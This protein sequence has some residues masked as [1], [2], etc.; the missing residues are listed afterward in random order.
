MPTRT[1]TKRQVIKTITAAAEKQQNRKKYKTGIN[2]NKLE[3][4]WMNAPWNES[5]NERE[6]DKD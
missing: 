3:K 5:I 6:G 4:A 1:T 2:E